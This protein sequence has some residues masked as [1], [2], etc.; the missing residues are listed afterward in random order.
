MPANNPFQRPKSRRPAQPAKPEPARDTRTRDD[1][2]EPA[3]WH[4]SSFELRRG[5]WVIETDLDPAI[6]H[7]ALARK[8][9]HGGGGST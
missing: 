4:D 2:A 5:L 6:T 7:G 3:S 8:R 1:N 9:S